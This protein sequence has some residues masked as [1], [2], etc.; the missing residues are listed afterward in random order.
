MLMSFSGDI[1]GGMSGR[2]RCDD[3]NE[4]MKGG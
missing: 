1:R 4:V 2:Q 3:V